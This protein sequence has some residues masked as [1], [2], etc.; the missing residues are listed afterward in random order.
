MA[1]VIPL[2]TAVHQ[3]FAPRLHSHLYET[4]D[5]LLE[6]DEWLRDNPTSGAFPAIE[7]FLG[8]D[9]S[10]PRLDDHNLPWTLRALTAL[11]EHNPCWGGELIMWE[12]KE[13]I[14]FPPGATILFPASFTRYSFTQVHAGESQ[15]SVSQYAQAGLFRYVE[16][17]FLNE[18]NFEAVAWKK[19]REARDRLRDA[20]MALTLGMYPVADDLY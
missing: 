18:A 20:R 11:G 3:R 13:V 5:L 16:N 10:P 9:E 14:T 17:G 7:F 12:E 15:Y 2:A 4:K 8:N 6:N 1:D 19:Q